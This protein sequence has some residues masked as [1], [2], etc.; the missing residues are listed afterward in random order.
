[1][2]AVLL[3]PAAIHAG[4]WWRV[5]TFLFVVPPQWSPLAVFFWLYLLYQYAQALENEWGEFRFCLFYLLG[6]ASTATAA[7][8]IVGQ[9]L[10]NIPLNT[11]LFFAFASLF[12]EFELLLFFVIPVRVKYLAWLIWIGLAWSFVTGG[13]VSRVGIAASLF[14]YVLFFGPTLWEKIRLKVEVYKNRRRFRS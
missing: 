9:T 7:L 2:S 13:F 12:P 4:E 11:T 14:N 3:D 10:S 1:L 6:A 5:V 8:F